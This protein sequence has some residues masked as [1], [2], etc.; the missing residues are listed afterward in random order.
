MSIPASKIV[1]VIPS[2]LSA[3]GNPLA[4]NGL[5]LSEAAVLPTGVPLPFPSATAVSTY[6][7][8]SSI[9]A[10][11]ANVYFNGFQNSNTK[12]NLLYFHR[13]AT[14]DVGA[15]LRAGR[16][17]MTLAQVKGITTGSLAITTDGVSASFTTVDLSGSY[18]FSDAAD[19][20]TAAFLGAS[21]PVITYDSSFGAF[22]ATSPTVGD[23][24]TLDYATGTIADTLKFTL[25]TG[26]TLSQGL[27][28][29][30]P[31]ETMDT[32]VTKTQNWIGFTTTTEPAEENMEAFAQWTAGKGVRYYYAPWDTDITQTENPSGFVGLGNYLKE[33]DVSGTI[34]LY[35]DPLA[36]AFVLGAFASVDFTEHNGRI[37]LKFKKATG[38]TINVTD[39]TEHDNLIA[40]GSNF[41]G[42][43][44]TAN[45]LFTFL[46]PGSISGQ[47]EW[48]D[49]Y[50]NAVWLNNQLQLAMIEML[51][52]QKSLPYNE[53]GYNIVRAA[54]SDPIKQALNCGVIRVGVPLSDAQIAEVNS[55][56]GVKIDGALYNTGFYFQVLPASAQVRGLR[57]SPPC[58]LWYMDG[59]SI[60]QLNLASIDIM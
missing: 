41:F 29:Q 47:Y 18:S 46:T 58:T 20:L 44:A 45:D 60:Q 43:F 12:P 39:E 54:A 22:V 40:N 3:G 49:S 33:N 16:L 36:A 53:E 9:E 14:S 17:G 38:V 28:T 31:A 27:S 59:Q 52:A 50:V 26:A 51:M 2:V 15:F 57:Q 8:A 21:K 10:E 48:A 37:T 1:N 32:V 19:R 13:Y 11:M 24:S 5:I 30:T 34:V 55:A 6:F 4:L 56:A 23:L 42:Q 7:G 25:A 35:D